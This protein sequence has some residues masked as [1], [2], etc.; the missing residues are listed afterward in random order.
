VS[1]NHA[2]DNTGELSC[3]SKRRDITV[4][5]AAGKSS[6]VVRFTK[7]MFPEGINTTIGAA[8]ASKDVK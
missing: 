8:F 1:Y 2:G 4:R 3:K 7:D 5:F 6:L